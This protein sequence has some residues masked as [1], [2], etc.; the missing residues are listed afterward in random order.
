MDWNR[1]SAYG[2]ACG[3]LRETSCRRDQIEQ[4]GTGILSVLSKRSVQ[5]AFSDYNRKTQPHAEY[6]GAG[7]RVAYTPS[8]HSDVSSDFRRRAE[9]S[10]RRKEAARINRA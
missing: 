3:M 6:Q 4:Q 1:E 9:S 5:P 2:P 10:R 7:D 8:A